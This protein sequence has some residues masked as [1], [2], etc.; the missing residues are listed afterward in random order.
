MMFIPILLIGLIVYVVINL[1]GGSHLHYKT[2]YANTDHAVDILK[3][4]FANGEITEEEY[5][6]KKDLLKP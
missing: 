3:Q 4:R 1:T 2:R 5:K 6:N